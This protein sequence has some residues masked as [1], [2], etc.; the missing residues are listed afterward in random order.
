MVNVKGLFYKLTP[1]VY[2]LPQVIYI[3]WLDYEW[4]IRK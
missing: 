1:H 2:D 4:I 3:K